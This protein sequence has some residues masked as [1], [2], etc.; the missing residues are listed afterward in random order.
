LSSGQLCLTQ[1]HFHSK[2]EIMKFW[3]PFVSGRRSFLCKICAREF[4][5]SS[6][7]Q[8]LKRHFNSVHLKL[9][10][11]KCN[12]CGLY[13]GLKYNLKVH[14]GRYHPECDINVMW[15]YQYHRTVDQV[16]HRNLEMYLSG[17][18]FE[19]GLGFDNYRVLFQY[20][21]VM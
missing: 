6:G 14:V 8:N 15:T 9:R 1:I 5:G 16:L 18:M 11:F 13:F 10:P 21:S 17:F 2:F 4:F 3:T 19:Q 12:V 7:S 20:K